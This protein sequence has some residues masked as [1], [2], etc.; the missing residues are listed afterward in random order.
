MARHAT[1]FSSSSS[2]M[3]ARASRNAVRRASVM[4]SPWR[5]P[6]QPRPD[7]FEASGSSM[8]ASPN[9]RTALRYR[10]VGQYLEA[11]TQ[12]RYIDVWTGPGP[13]V[14]VN[15]DNNGGVEVFVPASDSLDLRETLAALRKRIEGSR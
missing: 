11:D 3:A 4:G 15:S 10:V 7:A 8:D 9:A 1:S 13:A 12:E 5:M 14:L 2:V 6:A